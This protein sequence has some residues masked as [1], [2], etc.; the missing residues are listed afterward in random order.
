VD[1][2]RLV[3]SVEAAILGT[4]SFD[5][6]VEDL[7][8]H[9]ELGI[10]DNKTQWKGGT[11]VMLTLRALAEWLVN[12]GRQLSASQVVRDL[13]RYVT[14]PEVP[15]EEILILA[16]VVLDKPLQ[17]AGGIEMLPFSSL[18]APVWKE[19]LERLFGGSWVNYRPSVALRRSVHH[20]R[21][22]LEWS[23]SAKPNWDASFQDLDDIRLCIT[24]LGPHGPLYLGAWIQAE[25]WVP[26]L[27]GGSAQ[28]PEP[29][30][31]GN[32]PRNLVT[33]LRELPELYCKWTALSEKERKHLRVA[34]KRINSGVR[35]FAV[36]DSAID[37][38]IAM[39]AIFLSDKE[40]EQGELGFTLRLRAAR[41]L[42]TDKTTRLDVSKLFSHLYGFRSKAVHTGELGGVIKGISTESLLD[43]GYRLVGQAIRRIISEGEP[44]WSEI[45]FE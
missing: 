12:K 22:H 4:M 26:D 40:P 29:L 31:V 45:I 28:I 43:R 5:A 6:L 3:V 18:E 30:N 7:R 16:G 14:E 23:N 9:P 35:R 2:T 32:Y 19:H 25:P 38:G 39:E 1:S 11:G 41:Y 15:Y 34:L 20:P 37:L 21:T 24:A 17:L 8:T 13:E 10:F 36:V 27:G 33:D 42:G 44:S